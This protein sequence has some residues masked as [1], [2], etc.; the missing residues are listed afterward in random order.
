MLIECVECG[1]QISDKAIECPNCGYPMLIR[2]VKKKRNRQVRRKRLPNG[3]GRITE[4][5]GRG[6]RKPFRAMVTVGFTEDGKPIGKILKPEGYFATY[7][8]AYSALLK[9][10]DNPYD[11]SSDIKMSELFEKWIEHH[12]KKLKSAMSIKNIRC[13]WAHCSEIYQMSV[14]EIRVRHLKG[15]LEASTASNGVKLRMKNI[16]NMMMDYAVEYE[17]V[18]HNYARDFSVEKHDRLKESGTGAHKTFSVEELMTILSHKGEN[19]WI[20]MLIVQCFMGW[21]PNELCTLLRSNVNLE[22]G[23]IIGGSKTDAGQNRKVPIHSMVYDI[24]EKYNST[25]NEFL[26]GDIIYEQYR[27]A[28]H[29]ELRKMGITGHQPHDARVCFVTMA[30]NNGVDEYAIKKI[31]GHTISDLT[32]RVYTKRDFAWLKS[33]IEKITF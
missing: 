14:R 9:F 23:Y 6:L 21:R 3:F 24:I 4:L 16:L 30:K 22:E 28:F 7:N 31:I 32:E 33:E 10:H 11:L 13:D 18:E 2:E 12:S 27:H 26:F 29:R 1:K 17:L 25:G 19:I 20:D 8:E 5:K 15:M